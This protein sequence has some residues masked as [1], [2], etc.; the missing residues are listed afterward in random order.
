[1]FLCRLWAGLLSEIKDNYHSFAR[2]AVESCTA[3]CLPASIGS[4]RSITMAEQ[5]ACTVVHGR[6][7]RSFQVGLSLNVTKG[8][9]SDGCVEEKVPFPGAASFKCS[10]KY[11]PHWE[12]RKDDRGWIKVSVHSMAVAELGRRT[13]NEVRAVHAHMNLL[14]RNGPPAT[15]MA[16]KQGSNCVGGYLIARRDD[17]EGDCVVDGQFTVLCNIVVVPRISVITSCPTRLDHD[18]FM[19]SD[20]TDVSFQVDGE[21]FRAHRLVLA[22]RSPVFKASLF[23][24]MAE[25]TASS[26]AI[27]DMRASTFRSMLHYMYHGVLP[28]AI[29]EPDGGGD[30]SSQTLEVQHLF[31]SADRY[32]L[33]TLKE[34]CEDIL[35]TG[36][37]TST[38]LSNWE[39]AQ[40]R[41]CTRLKFKCLA[42][43][44]ADENFKQV[45][46]TDEYVDLM[47]NVPSFAIDVRGL[48]KRQRIA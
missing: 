31:V 24:S 40:E 22:A 16:V 34:M 32:G 3:I 28:A 41:A 19:A 13:N 26:I 18:I 44:G 37:S 5:K 17:I 33:D 21:T 38:V 25:S 6:E 2:E 7:D 47:K 30:A 36:I 9:S 12:H 8:L 39:F 27:E 14:A 4:R 35:S 15:A 11:W 20:L 43:L 42:F 1:M 46:I 29:L 10:V 48:I 45:A 23:G